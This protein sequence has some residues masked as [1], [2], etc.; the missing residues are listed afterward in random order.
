VVRKGQVG[1]SGSLDL[2]PVKKRHGRR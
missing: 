2:A 1:E